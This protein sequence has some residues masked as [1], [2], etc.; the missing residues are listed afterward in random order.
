M[1]PSAPRCPDCATALLPAPGRCTRCGLPLTGPAA[2]ELW[3]VDQA[4]AAN[5][6]QH[7]VLLDRRLPLLDAL[8]QQRSD[9]R[10][11]AAPTAAPA[12]APTAPPHAPVQNS[13][14]AARDT[15]SH[16]VQGVLLALGG[17][18]LAVAAVV[19]TVV[20][21]GRFGLA[22]KAA[23]LLAFTGVALGLPAW[24]VRRRLTM[25]AETVAL[26]GLVLMGADAY[27]AYAAGAFGL[28]QAD[29]YGYAAVASALIAVVAVSYPHF[30]PCRRVRRVGLLVA[31]L[32]V[33]LSA[34]ALRAT[35]T[36][37][38]LAATVT[39]AVNLAVVA[40]TSR[41]AGLRPERWIAATFAGLGAAFAVP[42]AAVLTFFADHP[43]RPAAV[44]ALAGMLTA[45]A[46]VL[47][48][49]AGPRAVLAGAGVLQVAAAAAGLALPSLGS[50]GALAPAGAGLLVA[51]AALVLPAAWRPGPVA[52]AAVLLGAAT[53]SILEPLALALAGPFGWLLQPWTGAAPGARAAV[54]P[55]W[56]WSAGSSVL[57]SVIVL[58]AGV[59]VLGSLVAGRRATGPICAGGVLMVAAV[60]PL[61]LDLTRPA[62]LVLQGVAAAACCITAALRRRGPQS[63]AAGAA[64][65][66]LLSIV[67]AGS[68]AERASTVG[69]LG[70]A[71]A[72][73]AGC[74]AAAGR[75]P[76]GAAAT[77]LLGAAVAAEA[78]ATVLIPG[79][80]A[81]AAAWAVLAVAASAAAAGHVIGGR[82]PRHA[83][84][85]V[86][87]V[88]VAAAAAVTTAVAHEGQPGL[89]L[90][91]AGSLV[92]LACVRRPRGGERELLLA[93][94]AL[95]LFGAVATIGRAVSE[96]YIA[97]YAWL[98]TGWTAA[99]QSARSGLAP[100]WAW[101]GTALVPAVLVVVAVGTT[102]GMAALFGRG[103]AARVAARVAVPAVA[104]AAGLLPLALDLPWPVA[105]VTTGVIAAT[106]LSAAAAARAEGLVPPAVTGPAAVVFAGTT[107]TWSLATA[108]A[109]VLALS[110][111]AAGTLLAAVFGRTPGVVRV[112]TVVAGSAAVLDALAVAM[113]A[114]L[115][116]YLAAFAALGVAAGL[117]LLAGV[118]RHHRPWESSA[119]EWVAGAGGVLGLRLTA[120]HPLALSVAL[121]VAGLT[122]GAVALRPDRRQAWPVGTALLIGS[123]WVRLADIGIT[124]PEAYTV[125]VAVVT[126]V[127]GALRRRR[128]ELSSWAA[129]G[130]GLA[131]GSL[132]SLAALFV[133]PPDAAR[134]L[135]LGAAALLVLLA[136]ARWRL[137][138]PLLIGGSVLGAV[139]T[140]E[141]APPVMQLVGSLPRWLPLATAGLL[142]LLLGATYEQRRRDL[143]RLRDAVTR[144]A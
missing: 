116:A 93:A 78:A 129:Y 15:S 133:Q 7:Q 82:L 113:A 134:P 56:S 17:L 2:A 79:G 77:G 6:L 132:P 8:R 57:A 32:P 107:V 38:A 121:A 90:A 22:G 73:L 98:A 62:A 85:L 108:P 92:V 111:V 70:L 101:S 125:P 135:A 27:A 87:C 137:K 47:A 45:C 43:A 30:V 71:A 126:V 63:W 3:N 136:G 112:A 59:A 12:V 1:D 120:G 89:L 40:L 14:R 34:V 55:V 33:P 127:L 97:P 119:C 110:G 68:L 76:I 109:T 142:L 53:V 10:L 66:S 91:A 49:R 44:L 37:A 42:V 65:L 128:R 21:W 141:L 19:F 20:A 100:G 140:H 50:A 4:L 74:A 36:G 29:R 26:L 64:G 23:I 41:R 81:T 72:L 138:A 24:L 52:A 86:G 16:S 124:A 122:V 103:V 139:A 61:A 105:L 51:V 114:G 84:A 117:G 25:T 130:P 118:L 95:P 35:V 31:Q 9:R 96:A 28:R 5:R 13:P 69:A 18:L 123:S 104:L 131:A 48:R 39:V 46:A 143:H 58:V 115:P 11:L 80:T 83:R 60:A 99:P 67:L 75:A 54:S 144:M 102:A 94:G 106:L 88:V